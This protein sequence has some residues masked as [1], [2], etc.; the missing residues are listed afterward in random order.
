MTSEQKL[1]EVIAKQEIAD[2]M[3]RYSR[4]LDWL[5][6]EG[7]ASCFWPNAPID[8]GFF[9]GSAQDFIQL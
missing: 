2:V 9:Q 4:T 7:Q 1:L 3:Q 8:Y 5:D 6:D